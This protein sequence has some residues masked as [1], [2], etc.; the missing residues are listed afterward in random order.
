MPRWDV[1]EQPVAGYKLVDFLGRGGFGEVWLAEAPGGIQCALKIIDLISPDAA[2]ELK[3]LRLMK[4]LRHPHLV[5]ITAFWIRDR[6][7]AV[8]S[9]DDLDL[10]KPAGSSPSCSSRWASGRR[11][12][13]NGWRR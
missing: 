11:A 3:A 10:T 13:R 8:L 7:G 1:G 2:K 12:W 5:P 9:L 6:K 4:R